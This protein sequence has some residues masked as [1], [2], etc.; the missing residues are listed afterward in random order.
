MTAEAPPAPASV[1]V[2]LV[3]ELLAGRWAQARA[4]TR[5]LVR[6]PTAPST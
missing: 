2:A 3:G 4:H 6:D 1:D 5:E